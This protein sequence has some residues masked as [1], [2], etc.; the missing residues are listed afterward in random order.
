MC[1]LEVERGA[2]PARLEQQLGQQQQQL[3]QPQQQLDQQQQQLGQQQ[4]QLG[5]QQSKQQLLPNRGPEKL[6]NGH[7]HPLP[8]FD[9][10]SKVSEKD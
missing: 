2:Q 1:D 3:G 5:Q 6:L 10:I 4:Q 7:H 8:N 9:I